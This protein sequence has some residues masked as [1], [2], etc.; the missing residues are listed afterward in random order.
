MS[1]QGNQK[2]TQKEP[3]YVSVKIKIAITAIAISIAVFYL[4]FSSFQSATTKYLNVEEALQQSSQG[5]ANNLGIIGKLVPNSFHRSTDGMTAYFSI[6]NEESLE[7]L[8]VSYSGEIGE[9]FFN[10]NAEII[11]RGSMQSDGLFKTQ[12]LSIKCP[13]KYVD[14]Y[15]DE[16]EL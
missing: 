2:V 5:E 6:T 7:T 4:G 15:E 16:K 12:E 14:N 13:S 8:P 3:A 9:I 10:Q 11:I 1:N